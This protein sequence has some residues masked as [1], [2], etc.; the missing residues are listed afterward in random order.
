M[1]LISQFNRV[2]PIDITYLLALQ[3]PLFTFRIGSKYLPNILKGKKCLK[4][5]LCSY[6]HIF[7]QAKA[8]NRTGMNGFA[9]HRVTIL[10][11]QHIFIYCTDTP[12]MYTI[13]GTI[14]SSAFYYVY[15]SLRLFS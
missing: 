14:L 10:P 7:L 1:L 3:V 11:P 4:R 6:I 15:A 8:R 5:F 13:V 9:V 2:S 12:Q